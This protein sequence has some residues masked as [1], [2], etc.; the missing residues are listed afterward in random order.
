MFGMIKTWSLCETCL[1]KLWIFN[2]CNVKDLIAEWK[3]CLW[4]LWMLKVVMSK[5][6]SY[7]ETSVKVA[8]Q[9]NLWLWSWKFVQLVIE[10]CDYNWKFVLDVEWNWNLWMLNVWNMKLVSALVKVSEWC[11]QRM[12]RIIAKVWQRCIVGVWKF[13]K[14]CENWN[15]KE[16]STELDLCLWKLQLKT[17]TCD[18]Q[19]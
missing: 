12:K 6:W 1:C 2:D 10:R 19:R 9:W 7:S 11:E 16:M 8:I 4:K 17:E 14:I 15:V 3:F 18:C 13:V 5:T